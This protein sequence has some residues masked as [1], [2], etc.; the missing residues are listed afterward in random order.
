MC[1]PP[2]L[3][4]C[5][6]KGVLFRPTLAGRHWTAAGDGPSTGGLAP[7][8]LE[9]GRIAGPD[10]GSGPTVGQP[11][12]NPLGSAEA[13]FRIQRPHRL[14]NRE[15]QIAV[16]VL[17]DSGAAIRIDY[18]STDHSIGIIPKL[19]G[20]FKATPAQTLPPSGK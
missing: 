11:F 14:A 15:L 7:L 20:A 18:D 4:A 9:D 6:A 1:R 8:D 19:P 2:I 5:P 16:E 13:Y 10:A 17:A 12:L 3:D